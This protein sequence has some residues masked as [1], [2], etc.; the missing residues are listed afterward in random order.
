MGIV[1]ER[2]PVKHREIRRNLAHAFSAKALRTQTDVIL[3]YVNLFVQQV[4]KYGD[5]PEGL[6]TNKVSISS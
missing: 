3:Q 1:S 2:D 5:T 6:D 4:K